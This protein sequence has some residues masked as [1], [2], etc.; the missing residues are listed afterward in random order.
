M[1]IHSP[2]H[3]HIK[4]FTLCWKPVDVETEQLEVA[5]WSAAD[6]NHSCFKQSISITGC[7]AQWGYRGWCKV[8]TGWIISCLLARWHHCLSLI[9]VAQTQPPNSQLLIHICSAAPGLIH[10]ELF[11]SWWVKWSEMTLH[12]KLFYLWI[13]EKYGPAGSFSANSC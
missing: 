3:I 6:L 7:S 1:N 4:I 11:I 12:N 10:Q 9:I 8:W 2:L 5:C 13:H